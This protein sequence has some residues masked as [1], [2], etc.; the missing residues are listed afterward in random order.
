MGVHAELGENR[1]Q[2]KVFRN[3]QVGG[4]VYFPEQ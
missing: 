4:N 3:V 2:W 1:R